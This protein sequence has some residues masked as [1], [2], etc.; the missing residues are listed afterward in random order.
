M[1]PQ[2]LICF[3]LRLPPITSPAPCPYFHA[4]A[5]HLMGDRMTDDANMTVRAHSEGH[6]QTRVHVYIHTGAVHN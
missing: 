1:E 6:K 4:S 3:S 2:R 5:S